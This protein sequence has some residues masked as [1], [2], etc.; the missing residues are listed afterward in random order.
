MIDERLDLW[1]D[2][3]ALTVFDPETFAGGSHA[4]TWPPENDEAVRKGLYVY[5]SLQGDCTFT[6][7]L[8]DVGLTDTEAAVVNET[9][10]PLGLTVRSGR[11]YISGMDYPGDPIDAHDGAGHFVS[12]EVG[13]YDVL[14][15]E[16]DTLS[17]RWTDALPH[18]VLV[19]TQRLS[20]FRG[21][22]S[23]L[24]FTGGR[25]IDLTLAELEGKEV[26]DE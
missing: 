16:L 12:V 9:L 3:A 4:P 14:V 17:D 25:R 8:T 7:R 2:V 26:D 22:G 6:V 1:T 19:V 20:S 21:I 24:R 18:F 13:E 5:V 10:G 15:H 11:V 23:G